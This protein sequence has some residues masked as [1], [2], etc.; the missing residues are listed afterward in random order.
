[1][2][3]VRAVHHWDVDFCLLKIFERTR[4]GFR[5]ILLV[6]GRRQRDWAADCQRNGH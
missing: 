6:D 3:R 5:K 1:M 4:E 2:R